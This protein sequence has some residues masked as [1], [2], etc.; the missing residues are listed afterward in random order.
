MITLLQKKTWWIY[1]HDSSYS[2]DPCSWNSILLEHGH[3]YTITFSYKSF[4]LLKSPFATNCADYKSDKE[5]VSRK[6][7]LR[8]CKLESSIKKCGVIPHYIEVYRGEASK[9]FAMNDH[10]KTCLASLELGTTCLRKCPH[11]DCVKTY[12]KTSIG[13]KVSLKND[14]EVTDQESIVVEFVLPTE[15]ETTFIHRPR[16]ETVEFICYLAST[17]SLWFGVSMLSTLSWFDALLIKAKNINLIK[18]TNNNIRTK[19][20]IIKPY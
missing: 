10:D 17:V 3:Y 7:C 9:N 16:I 6:D 8:N 1:L 5:F 4:H 19:K 15:P 2:V 18:T 20:V 13:S 12:Y 14:S 11:V